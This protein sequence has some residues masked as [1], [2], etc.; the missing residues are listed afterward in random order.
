MF[1]AITHKPSRSLNQGELTFLPRKK[2]DVAKACEQHA[3]YCE[4]LKKLGT[5]VITLDQNRAL[6]DS[7][8]VEDTAL[9]LDKTA[10]LLPLGANSRK[11]E[12]NLIEKNLAKFRTIVR[13]KPPARIDGGDI[14]I[15]GK[16]LF[17]GNSTRTNKK[18]IR[19]LHKIVTP[20]GFEIVKVKVGNCLHLKTACTAL[21]EKTVLIN[22]EWVDAVAFKKFK[23]IE[24]PIDE[25]F[26]ANVMRVGKTI[27]IHSGFKRTQG[28][29]EQHGCKTKSIDISE[30]LK[31]EAGLTCMSLVFET[32][33]EK[34]K[35]VETKELSH[36]NSKLK[37]RE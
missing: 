2:I 5:D 17:V 11:A 7:V 34:K 27:C 9:V 18:G 21:D 16:T 37:H 3:A 33:E 19:A 8:F 30:F 6:P 25:P 31:A 23:Q 13:I 32:S 24:V 10:V 4:M 20:L 26:A 28:L 15:I 12:S 1:T 36:K 14:L 35:S 22:P 29:I